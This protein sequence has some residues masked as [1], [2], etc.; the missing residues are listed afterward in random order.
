MGTTD[1]WSILAHDSFYHLLQLKNKKG[2]ELKG[3]VTS[4]AAEAQKQWAQA[5]K[6]E[7]IEKKEGVV[8]IASTR[9]KGLGLGSGLGLGL[10]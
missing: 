8:P 4:P 3:T 7:E 9:K 6:S 1:I 5:L 2:E 10:V